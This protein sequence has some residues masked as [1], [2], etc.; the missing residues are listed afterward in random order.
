M[1]ILELLNSEQPNT[2][3]G[4][5]MRSVQVPYRTDVPVEQP[6][7]Q[8]EPKIN[9]NALIQQLIQKKL[10][11]Q[12]SQPYQYQ[13]PQIT[14]VDKKK[15]LGNALLTAGLAMMARS[16]SSRNLGEIIGTGGLQGVGQYRNEID[17][18]LAQ[19]MAM[20]EERRKAYHEGLTSENAN[21]KSIKDMIDLVTSGKIT[22]KEAFRYTPESRKKYD[23]T[24]DVSALE[25]P[26]PKEGKPTV[27]SF[28]EGERTVD[29][30]W[31]PET[32]TWD[33]L[34]SGP[35]Y[36]PASGNG[37]LTAYQV[38]NKTT[39]LR[40]EFNQRPEIKEM[41]TVMPKFAALDKAMEESRVTG[42]KVAADQA[43]ITLFNKMTDPNSVVRE[44]E[45][46]R[47]PQNLSLINRLKGKIA[48]VQQGGAG[49]TDEDRKAILSMAKQFKVAYQDTFNTV[50]NE[51]TDYAKG[52]GID[53]EMVIGKRR[54][55]EDSPKPA[56]ANKR[57][58]NETPEQYLKRTSK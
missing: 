32:K 53:P 47:T 5:A 18:A 55:T 11:E 56:T 26:A 45:Y 38:I 51:Y 43:M 25:T 27:H 24:G 23:E 52:F 17:S 35:R 36:K 10:T 22:P 31:N 50:A 8:T 46:A 6:P 40:K 19:K 16:G 54:K 21:V 15:A 1:N 12:A 20:E 39:E 30:Q 3:I 2:S 9:T 33:A 44:S 14:D 7:V 49:L 41:N 42:N 37:G 57:L 4:D 58:P 34:S 29:K 13:Q 48:K 28:T